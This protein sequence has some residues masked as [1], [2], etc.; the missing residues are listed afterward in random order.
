M[1]LTLKLLARTGLRSLIIPKMGCQSRASTY[2]FWFSNEHS[3]FRLAELEA[4]FQY[5]QF[6]RAILDKRKTNGPFILM[7]FPDESGPKKLMS[8]TV[9]AHSC[10]ELW[11]SG[12]L[13]EDLHESMKQNLDLV[14][15]FVNDSFQV[16]VDTYGKTIQHSEKLPLIETFEY[17]PLEGKVDLKTPEL[18]LHLIQFYGID[19]NRIPEKPY[20][21]Y[22]GRWLVD[23]Q[24]KL[25]SKI[26][27]K[28][29]KFIGN[30]SMDPLL[31]LLMANLALVKPNDIVL[32]PF[33]GT[34]SLLVAAAL[35]DAYVVGNDIDYLMLHAKTSSSRARQK[36]RASD[37][38]VRA[39]LRQYGVEDRYLDVVVADTSRPMW[40]H[41]FRF[42]AIIT[43]P[44]YGIREPTERIG[45][46]RQPAGFKIKEEHLALHIPSKISYTLQD[47]FSD[48]LNYSARSLQ[49]GGRV[50]LWMPISRTEYDQNKLPRNPALALV[51]NCEQTLTSTASRRL[52]VYEKIK[53]PTESCIT[54]LDGSALMYRFKFF[55]VDPASPRKTRKEKS[56]LEFGRSSKR[57]QQQPS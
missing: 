31:S 28:E 22:F 36:K 53:E 48:L 25:V 18:S 3:N 6:D 15:P 54:E 50:V 29:R 37:E 35:M 19:P 16:R 10:Y 57:G 45:T 39:N 7:D 32:D 20:H 21:Q 1:H 2:L 34:G 23:G 13:L 55:E 42:D 14:E 33:V 30:T 49:I 46:H 43:D 11:A 24:R 44:P 8:R 52:L 26:N 9:L 40:K 51:S 27:L 5:F 12:D 38:S 17:M 56:V 47:I 41:D 4:L